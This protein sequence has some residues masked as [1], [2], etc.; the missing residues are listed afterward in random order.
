MI[1]KEARSKKP[2]QIGTNNDRY[3]YY[4]LFN[5]YLCYNAYAIHLFAWA[6][7]LFV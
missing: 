2:E 5:L 1:F 4:A 3:K 6:L 7:F